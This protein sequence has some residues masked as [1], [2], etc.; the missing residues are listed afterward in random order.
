MPHAKLNGQPVIHV[1]IGYLL[2]GC[3]ASLN[4]KFLQVL[5]RC[6][7]F[8]SAVRKPLRAAKNTN[9]GLRDQR[10]ALNVRTQTPVGDP[11]LTS[12]SNAVFYDD[13]ASFRAD[14]E[15]VVA[16]DQS[17]SERSIG[18][19]IVSYEGKQ[20]VPFQKAM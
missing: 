19:H 6:I 13:I 5:I 10:A 11:A 1:G 16:I 2:E 20:E 17:V 14:L 9:A 12:W 15:N 4:R 3:S 18:L 8:C 7:V